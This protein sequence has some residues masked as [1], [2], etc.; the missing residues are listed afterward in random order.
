[1]AIFGA[2]AESVAQLVDVDLLD[3]GMD[4]AAG[5]VVVFVGY[6]D[7]VVVVHA[8]YDIYTSVQQGRA[9]V[10]PRRKRSQ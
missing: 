4:E 1:M 6:P 8:G 5:L 3:V 9:S 2:D 10:L 7:P